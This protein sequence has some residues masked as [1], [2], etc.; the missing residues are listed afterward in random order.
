MIIIVVMWWHGGS[1]WCRRCGCLWN[2]MLLLTASMFQGRLLEIL[3]SSR[4]ITVSLTSFSFS[5]RDFSVGCY[6]C[7][8]VYVTCYLKS[9]YNVLMPLWPEPSRICPSTWHLSADTARTLRAWHGWTC[10]LSFL[11]SSPDLLPVTL[12]YRLPYFA[13]ESVMFY[14]YSRTK[15]W[16]MLFLDNMQHWY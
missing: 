12:I 4:S 7:F 16:K 8:L 3:V 2:D 9:A 10:Y 1:R 11:C 15:C 5:A 13:C 14:F 6:I